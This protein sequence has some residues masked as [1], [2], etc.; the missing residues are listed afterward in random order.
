V[1]GA[2]WDDGGVA[3]NASDTATGPNG[4]STDTPTSDEAPRQEQPT[5]GG[6]PRL[7]SGMRDM[8]LSMIVLAVGVLVLA[9]L[10]RSCSFSP[11]GPSTNP[12]SVP[13]VDVTGELRAAAS[14]VTFPL[15]QPQLPDGW[16][17][18]SDSVDPL[19][20]NGKDKAVRI[21]WIAPDGRYLQVSQSNASAL[22]LVRAAAAL[23]D[24]ATIAPTG[25]ETVNGTQ[26]TVYPGIRDEQSWVTDL[27]PE[28]LFVTGN[29][30]T[31]DFRTL[32]V[33]VQT[34]RKVSPAGS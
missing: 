18:N 7:H 29:G 25:S 22:D 11:G 14:Q 24:D 6:S 31:A 27:G 8:L 4:D 32:A 23:G 16:R 19:G 20:P 33:A 13:T 9:A 34:G 28:R 5:G 17:P 2:T 1:T 26:W 30:T 3:D 15:R 10:T 21:G 12:S